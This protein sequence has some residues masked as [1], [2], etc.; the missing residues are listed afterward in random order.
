M[1]SKVLV[2]SAWS[3][4]PVE[5]APVARVIAIPANK[6]SLTRALPD[7]AIP[8]T[9][10]VTTSPPVKAHKGISGNAEPD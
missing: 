8:A 4:R 2:I 1:A 10:K 6:T 5:M 3:C 7:E 9:I